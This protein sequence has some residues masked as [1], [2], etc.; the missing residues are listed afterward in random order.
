LLLIDDLAMRKLPL[1]AAEDLL[2]VI[3]RRHG[4]VSAILARISRSRAGASCSAT[5]R[6]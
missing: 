5:R 2:E 4:R 1:A 3:M 6:R